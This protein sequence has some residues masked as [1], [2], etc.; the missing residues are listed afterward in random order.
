M[1][2]CT[3]YTGRGTALKT[4]L[5]HNRADL[6]RELLDSLDGLRYPFIRDVENAIPWFVS[7]V[8][9]LGASG[10]HHHS[11]VA[12]LLDHSLRVACSASREAR[13]RFQD[14]PHR[15]ELVYMCA[16]WGLFHDLGK[17]ASCALKCSRCGTPLGTGTL[18]DYLNWHEWAGERL[19]YEPQ[20]ACLHTEA[21]R[22]FFI[23]WLDRRFF[24]LPDEI[25]RM[26]HD[27]YGGHRQEDL[28]W[29]DE[30]V[31]KLNGSDGT[32][33]KLQIHRERI[34]PSLANGNAPDSFEIA[35]YF[36]VLVASALHKFVRHGMPD[37]K[38]GFHRKIDYCVFPE[39]I[40]ISLKDFDTLLALIR[41]Y[42]LD[43]HGELKRRDFKRWDL[44][45]EL[46]REGALLA[47]GPGKR[48]LSQGRV[49]F[50]TFELTWP[51]ILLRRSIDGLV[52]LPG[53]PLF[54]LPIIFE[55]SRPPEVPERID[56]PNPN[57]S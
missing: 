33:N 16:L 56:P 21:S 11:G 55:G 13:S 44:V 57:S 50:R 42:Y 53:A 48:T 35:P 9:T 15:D 46:Y 39:F 5:L 24:M 32:E 4:E 52:I 51:L 23:E 54:S 14:H 45:D 17:R 20:E 7:Y 37:I 43:Q 18:E 41:H 2:S 34:I 26:I 27:H 10:R 3:P 30:T 25:L 6:I 19:P 40:A 49:I 28:S 29:I 22:R 1:S 36:Y 31:H 8:L 47:L 38:K 12:G